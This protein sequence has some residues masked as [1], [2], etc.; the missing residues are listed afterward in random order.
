M[1][2]VIFYG[3]QEKNSTMSLHTLNPKRTL[4]KKKKRPKRTKTNK[5]KPK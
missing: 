4:K 2:F 3:F 5:C 1:F